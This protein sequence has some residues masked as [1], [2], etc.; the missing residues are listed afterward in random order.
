[1]IGISKYTK[2]KELWF[3]GEVAYA[4][5]RAAYASL[6]RNLRLNM[7]NRI[8]N[9]ILIKISNFDYYLTEITRINKKDRIKVEKMDYQED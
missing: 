9:K 8:S 4:M 7:G 5:F 3:L 1:M 2:S 6:S